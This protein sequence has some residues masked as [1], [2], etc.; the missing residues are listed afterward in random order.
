MSKK[1]EGTPEGRYE[2][3][4]IVGAHGVRGD[5][6]LLPLTDFPER[7]LGMKKLDVTLPGKPMRAY[8][9]SRIEPYEGKNTFFLRLLGVEG[10]DAAE[11]LR[12]AV[13]TVAKDERVE[14]E[15][16]EYW[17]DDIIGL[18][19]FDAA[20]GDKLGEITEVMYTGSNDVYVVKTSDGAS[21]AIPAVADVI[22]NVDTAKGTMTVNIPEGLWD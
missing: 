17:L 11:A 2:I 3:G 6:L 14:L 5:M 22:K 13:V 15:E 19:V 12:G 7:F 10:R 9:V 21:K 4:K 18:A 16:D 20:T 8:T 1:T